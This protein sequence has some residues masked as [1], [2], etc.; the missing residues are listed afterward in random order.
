MTETA[1]AS[2]I[3]PDVANLAQQI[4][5]ET[6]EMI[7]GVETLDASN[8]LSHADK[9]DSLNKQLQGLLIPVPPSE[10][11]ASTSKKS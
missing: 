8:W 3:H 5:D 11:K 10:T 4:V 9:I 6:N 2:D 7:A 1:P